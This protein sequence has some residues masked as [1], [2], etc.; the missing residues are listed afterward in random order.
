MLE[1]NTVTSAN[2]HFAIALRVPGKTN[3]RRGIEQMPLQTAR[4]GRR[5]YTGCWERGKRGRRNSGGSP[6]TAAL[7]D[8][9]E[10][11]PGSGNKGSVRGATALINRGR[12]GSVK[13]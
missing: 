8:S 12:V 3:A 1:E 7:D 13:R 10:R 9:I 6:G 5:T 11:I 2:G 4:V